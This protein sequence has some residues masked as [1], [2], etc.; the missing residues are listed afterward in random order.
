MNDIKRT[1]QTQVLIDQEGNLKNMLRSI[2]QEAITNEFNKFIGAEEYER[3]DTRNGYRNGYYERD[4][5]LR[6]GTITLRICRDRD[7]NFQTN[8]FQRYHRS[9]KAFIIGLQEMYVSGVSTRKVTKI[10][11]EL[12]G[13]S[14]SK[15]KV[16]ELVK[17]I[18]AELKIWRERKLIQVYKYLIFDA[19]YEKIRENNHVV[20]KASVV[21]IG[22]TEN[23]ERDIIGCDVVNSESYDA[24]DTFVQHLKDRGLTGVEYVVTDKNKGLCQTLQKQFQGIK[25]QRCQ[26]HFMRNLMTKLSKSIQKDAMLLL[27][28]VFNAPTKEKAVE[29]VQKVKAF[30]IE[31]KKQ[32]IADWLDENIE[33]SLTVFELPWEHRKKMK[34][35]NM[36]ERLN[37]ELKR[38]SRVIRIFPNT[39]SCLRLLTALC[40]DASESCVAAK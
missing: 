35:T 25:I 12:C 19:R 15:S 40:Q 24:W 34:S 32:D 21:A 3:T 31:K 16:S 33:E 20:S 30:L 22:I 18:D 23:G 39:E 8:V 37:Q 28:D 17:E 36:L 6:V 10:I 14:V 27:Q 5:Q 2:L 7:G 26:V 38:R 1:Q 29:R 13:F 11:E 4:L 9:E